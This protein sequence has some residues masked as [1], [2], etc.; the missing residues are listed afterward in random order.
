MTTINLERKARQFLFLK[1]FTVPI[2]LLTILLISL[3][4]QTV[5]AE[6]IKPARFDRPPHVVF[7]I[8]GLLGDPTTFGD[9]EALLRERYQSENVRIKTLFYPS[10]PGQGDTEKI[11]AFTPLDFAK[12]INSQMISYLIEEGVKDK[13]QNRPYPIDINTP[14]SFIV[15][16]Q[17]GAVVLHYL[18]SC[19]R[20]NLQQPRC[21]YDEG[22]QL[23][24]DAGWFKSGGPQWLSQAWPNL[25]KELN[26]NL[27]LKNVDPPSNIHTFVSLASPFWGS[28]AANK[29]VAINNNNKLHKLTIGDF[30][31]GNG[32]DIIEKL[33]LPLGQIKNLSMG[34][35]SVAWARSLMLDRNA[36]DT[37]EHWTSNTRWRSRYPKTL[38]V[39]NV[40]GV[41]TGLHKSIKNAV[42]RQILKFE[43]METD[44]VVSA[45]EARLDFIYYIE[46]SDPK[47]SPLSGRTNLGKGY[48][49]VAS[50]H[51]PGLEMAA[52]D[53]QGIATVTRAN[54][55][56]HLGFTVTKRALD[57]EFGLAQSADLT[58][59]EKDKFLLPKLQNFTVDLKLLTPPGYFR[60]FGI[61]ESNV[62]ITPEKN[63]FES[64]KVGGTLVLDTNGQNFDGVKAKSNYYQ[65]YYHV[66]RF[67][68]KHAYLPRKE[69]LESAIQR[70]GLVRLDYKF[71]LLGF[72]LK[73]PDKIFR[74]DVFPTLSSYGEFYIQPY[75][76]IKP[77][78]LQDEDGNVYLARVAG[79]AKNDVI[80]YMDVNNNLHRDVFPK[81]K[82]ATNL[83]PA[84]RVALLG[85]KSP[86][87][88]RQKKL[89]YF[90]WIRLANNTGFLQPTFSA[91]DQ[92]R[93]TL[94]ESFAEENGEKIDYAMPLEIIGRYKTTIVDRYLRDY[95]QQERKKFEKMSD[96]E[97]NIYLA[98]HPDIDLNSDGSRIFDRY[99]VTAP[100]IRRFD[101]SK[102]MSQIK[103]NDLGPNNQGLRWVNVVDVDVLK[104][105]H[106][107]HPDT[108]GLISAPIDNH[109]LGD[110]SPFQ[111]APKSKF[112]KLYYAE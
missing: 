92:F 87:F 15:H 47:K 66:G 42:Q 76:P 11:N 101:S 62:R 4:V 20:K 97:Q 88:H 89:N 54:Q 100:I 9:M 44:V 1:T 84:C 68:E 112:R 103:M 60:Q 96:F 70:E 99:L 98:E 21:F 64:I 86:G 32:N 83:L 82:V 2:I 49:P 13:Q 25:Q 37:E 102:S 94:L 48:Y 6:Q 108:G 106:V 30:V 18:N 10:I 74:I 33:N 65:T 105:V 93:D 52:I 31:P 45:P 110:S 57:F 63:V 19:Y 80:L 23:M 5:S 29:L 40:A 71:D 7:L 8:H 14:I 90:Q 36:V 17:G 56:N 3:L 27:V 107:I 72:E 73:S 34:S 77:A 81:G 28:A 109:C 53:I 16:S 55:S 95:I 26:S 35:E 58:Q 79:D 24:A 85:K 43:E 104:Y 41:I 46:N 38:K 69:S 75:Q 12:I 50:A 22:V 59:E 91:D 67:D 61:M 51:L 39:Y 78:R 111:Y